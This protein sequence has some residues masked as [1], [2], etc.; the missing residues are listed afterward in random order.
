MLN[1][2]FPLRTHR[3]IQNSGI[4]ESHLRRSMG[5]PLLDHDQAHPIVHQLYPLGMSE[6]MELEIEEVSRLI[7][8]LIFFGQLVQC[9]GNISGIE[10]VSM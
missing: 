1:G 6:C 7:T 8:H 5:H 9:P 4:D 10:W 3:F 2:L